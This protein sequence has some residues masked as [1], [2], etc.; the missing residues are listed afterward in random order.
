MGAPGIQL[1]PRGWLTHLVSLPPAGSV[2]LPPFHR[3]A[4]G[5][6]ASALGPEFTLVVMFRL[7]PH[8]WGLKSHVRAFVGLV[9]RRGPMRSPPKLAG[10]ALGWV[11]PTPSLGGIRARAARGGGCPGDLPPWKIPSS[12]DSR[13]TCSLSRGVP[14]DP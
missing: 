12:S 13:L 2:G 8:P 5:D 10:A 4:D 3:S 1:A 14:D 9:M 11:S 7:D 6:P